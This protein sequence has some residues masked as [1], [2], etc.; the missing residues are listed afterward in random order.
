MTPTKTTHQSLRTHS[1]THLFSTGQSVRLKNAVLL[2]GAVYRITAS[3]PPSGASPQYRIRN[4]NE[5]FER[6]ASEADLELVTVSL[7][8]E[9]DTTVERHFG[10]LGDTVGT[11]AGAGA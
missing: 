2:A 3:L 7:G 10:R 1:A 6:M 11:V 4:E 5:T 9:G 8:R